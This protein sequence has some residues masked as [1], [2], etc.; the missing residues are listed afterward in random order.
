M[1]QNRVGGPQKRKKKS[2][3]KEAIYSNCLEQSRDTTILSL[4]T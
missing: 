4:Y 3:F 1:I 2:D